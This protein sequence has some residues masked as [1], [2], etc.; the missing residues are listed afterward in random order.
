MR[1]DREPRCRG[2]RCRPHSGSCCGRADGW[3]GGC[4]PPT[5]AA[6]R[7]RRR[8]SRGSTTGRSR[9]ATAAAADGAT[10]EGVARRSGLRRHGWCGCCAT[11]GGCSAPPGAS[12][13]SAW[14]SSA[15]RRGAGRAGGGASAALG[16]MRSRGSAGARRR[17]RR[18][19]PRRSS[20]RRRRSLSPPRPDLCLHAAGGR[21]AADRRRRRAAAGGRRQRAMRPTSAARS[22]TI[23]R[24]SRSTCRSRR[25]SRALDLAHVHATAMAAIEPHAAFASRFAPLLRVGNRRRRRVSE[26]PLCRLRGGQHRRDA[27]GVSRSDE[28]PRHQG[29]G[30]PRRSRTSRRS[31]SSRISA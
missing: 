8:S 18:D 1:S 21:S 3:R 29:P 11:P 23:T 10:L 13:W 24:R 5:Y 22:S 26:R 30:L 27:A 17:S 4:C 28:L 15:G 6:R 16:A 20:R 2:P 7:H 9:R 31:T 12:R 19:E 25:R 14:R